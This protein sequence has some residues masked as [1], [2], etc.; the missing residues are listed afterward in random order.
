M[1][2]SPQTTEI[3][4]DSGG[5]AFPVPVT[6]L[7]NQKHSSSLQ[8]M[9]LRD[10]FAAAALQGMIASGSSAHYAGLGEMAYAAA[11]NLLAAR[12]NKEQ[13]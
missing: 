12:V 2:S 6:T 1:I 5:P 9:S 3:N 8:G 10:Y 7:D 11:D 13:L 4:M